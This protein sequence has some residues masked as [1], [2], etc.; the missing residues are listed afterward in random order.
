MG[1]EVEFVPTT[2]PTLSKDFAAN[3]FDIAMGGVSITLARQLI[4]SFST[5]IMREGEAPIS[6]C[7]E[8]EKFDTLA[9]IDEPGVRVVVNPGGTTRNLR[10]PIS[11]K[12][13]C[14]FTATTSPSSRRLPRG[15]P[16]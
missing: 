11:R 8:T 16:T 3:T 13:P 14:A 4:G 5:P 7:G 10:G 6:R 9:E 2:W 12:P 1:V 15:G